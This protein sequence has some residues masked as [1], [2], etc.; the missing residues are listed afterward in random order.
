MTNRSVTKDLQ[1]STFLETILR[2]LHSKQLESLS[3]AVRHRIYETVLTSGLKDLKTIID[4][5]VGEEK[6]MHE[7]LKKYKKDQNSV[8]LTD[9]E[10]M[11]V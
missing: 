9:F 11:M 4:E 7:T 10:K 5:V 6:K 1:P 2:P 3:D 8:D